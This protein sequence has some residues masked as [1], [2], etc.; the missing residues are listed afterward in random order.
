MKCL[1][2]FHLTQNE[3]HVIFFILHKMKYIFILYKT[4]YIFILYKTKYIFYFI[5]NEMYVPYFILRKTK[6]VLY[7]SSCVKINV[8]YDFILHKMKSIL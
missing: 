7:F 1:L 2:Y 6:C 8:C 5:Q 3:T 4:K